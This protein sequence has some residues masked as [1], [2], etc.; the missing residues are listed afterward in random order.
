MPHSAFSRRL[1]RSFQ[2]LA[3]GSRA[4]RSTPYRPRLEQLEP[5]ELLSFAG[6]ATDQLRESYGQIP[7]SFEANQR[8]LEYDFVVAPGADPGRIALAFQGAQSVEIDAQGELVA[9]S[10]GGD[11]VE[12]APVM[13]QDSGNGR[14][15]VSGRYV[16]GTDRVGFHVDG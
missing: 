15:A 13:Y 11:V 6:T 3:P 4:M 2:R 5:R 16:L 12:H 8:Q 10:A 1:I 14:Q 9:H 7:L